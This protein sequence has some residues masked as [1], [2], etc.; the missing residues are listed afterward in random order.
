M[1]YSILPYHMQAGVRR[2]IERGI[3]TGGF[4][5]AIFTNNFV[6][7]FEKADDVNTAYMRTYAVMLHSAPMGCWGSEEKVAEWQKKGGLVGLA[8]NNSD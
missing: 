5:Y 1:D 6:R 3:P 7:A 8:E 4:L 2:Y